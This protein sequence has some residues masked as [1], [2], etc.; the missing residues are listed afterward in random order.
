MP[1][2]RV[3]TDNYTVL[4]SVLKFALPADMESSEDS[5]R[6]SAVKAALKMSSND[7]SVGSGEWTVDIRL[8]MKRSSFIHATKL[9]Q[10]PF[11]ETRCARCVLY[12]KLSCGRCDR[13][14]QVVAQKVDLA[15]SLHPNTRVC[16]YEGKREDTPAQEWTLEV[17]TCTKMKVCASLFGLGRDSG[18]SVFL[19]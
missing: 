13:R 19:R 16:M 5:L 1:L 17:L 3:V 12:V 4:R 6:T 11:F 18:G 9:C 7:L 10:L 8:W 2:P 15:L 14:I